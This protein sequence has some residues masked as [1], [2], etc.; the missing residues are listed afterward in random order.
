[1]Q[2]EDTIMKDAE[3]E[4]PTLPTI[5]PSIS[6][7]RMMKTCVQLSDLIQPQKNL[8]D[9]ELLERLWMPVQRML[10]DDEKI[11]PAPIN[12]FLRKVKDYPEDVFISKVKDTAKAGQESVTN[13]GVLF[14]E[15]V[16]SFLFFL[17]CSNHLPYLDVFYCDEEN[18]NQNMYV[19]E[20]SVQG[21]QAILTSPYLW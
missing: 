6:M 4:L 8:P 15:G 10:R 20:G 13:W 18:Q 17:Q 16:Y 5:S 19:T 1:M 7:E 21:A 14:G 2:L 9:D 11:Q 3:L 12:E